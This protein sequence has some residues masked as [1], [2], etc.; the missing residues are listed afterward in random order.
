MYAWALDAHPSAVL[1]PH[2]N[3]TRMLS[4]VVKAATAWLTHTNKTAPKSDLF[5]DV[6][7][8]FVTFNL[9]RMPGRATYK[10]VQIP[11]PHSCLN[12]ESG[13]ELC[14]ITKDGAES[15]KNSLL[16]KPVGGFTKV[17]TVSK[18]QTKYK[19]FQHR[20]ELVARFAAFFADDRIVT[21]MPKLCGKIFSDRRKMPVPVRIDRG[22]LQKTLASARDSVWLYRGAQCVSVKVGDSSMTGQQIADNIMAV[23]SAAAPHFAKKWR[24]IQSVYLTARDTLSLPLYKS[25]PYSNTGTDGMD[26]EQD[27]DDGEED[28]EEEGDSDEESGDEEEED[29]DDDEE[30]DEPAAAL[31]PPSKKKAAASSAAALVPASAGAASKGK[32][33]APAAK[34]PQK[35]AAAGQKRPRE[36]APV[37][38]SKKA[39]PAAAAPAA[40]K[41]KPAPVAAAAA[42]QGAGKKI[43]GK[44][45][46]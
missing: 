42:P 19:V 8:C 4:Q 36:E 46:R 20:R 31:A 14:L 22:N 32:P 23:T 13:L 35:E 15:I 39:V 5:E 24:G 27:D 34:Q 41:G 40:G 45:G 38:A 17:L 9:K 12:P 28:E 2:R 26:V 7:P 30:D 44:S 3:L 43:G 29:I 21:M 6:V 16:E 37:A 11:V 10:P 25:L 18:L 1:S 33:A